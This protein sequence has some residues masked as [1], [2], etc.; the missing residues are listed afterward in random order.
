MVWS[1]DWG[2]EPLPSND[3]ACTIVRLAC[4]L[5]YFAGDSPYNNLAWH[6]SRWYLS[7]CVVRCGC[8]QSIGGLL[9]CVP[10][11]EYKQRRLAAD[12]QMASPAGFDSSA[13]AI[14]GILIWIHKLKRKDWSISGVGQL[15]FFCE[16][17]NK[18]GW[19]SSRQWRPWK[20]PRNVDHEH[21]LY[22]QLFGVW[23]I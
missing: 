8:L 5:R 7:K 1:K 3:L 19:L 6:F 18:F 10:R 20:V 12:F 4:S 22:V 2:R 9:H 15:K 14:D 11:E 21:W 13:G 17:K 16:R 23:R